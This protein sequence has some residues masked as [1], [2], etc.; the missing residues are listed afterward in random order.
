MSGLTCR[1]GVDWAPVEPWPQQ[2]RWVW[3]VR[4]PS[5]LWPV[6]RVWCQDAGALPVCLSDPVFRILVPVGL[7]GTE[8]HQSKMN[9]WAL[10]SISSAGVPV[11][12]LPRVL[13]LRAGTG[14]AVWPRAPGAG[15]LLPPPSSPSRLLLAGPELRAHGT[16]T[17]ASSEVPTA[18]LFLGTS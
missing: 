16:Q 6:W 13:L 15:C 4:C 14:A 3:S 17:E 2:R 5:L 10:I 12:T 9:T 7:K 1:L 8:S 18:P 11:S